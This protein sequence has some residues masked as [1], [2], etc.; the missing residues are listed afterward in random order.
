MFAELHDGRGM[1]GFIKLSY[2]WVS[3][4]NFLF[5]L[6]SGLVMSH[7]LLAY[8]ILLAK[9]TT[10]VSVLCLTLKPMYFSSASVSHPQ[11]RL[12]TSVRNGFPKCAI[13]ARGFHA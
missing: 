4:A 8:S 3:L 10:I 7:T 13:I 12:K 6:H 1:H 9:K 2:S 5:A 11:L